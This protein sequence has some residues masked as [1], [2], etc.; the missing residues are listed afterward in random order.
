MSVTSIKTTGGWADTAVQDAYAL[1][2]GWAL[3]NSTMLW[4]L[5]DHMPEQ[6][7][8]PGGSVTEQLNAFYSAADVAAAVTALDEETDVTPVKSP[9]NSTVTYT[10]VERGF[11]NKRTIKLARRG[12]T[13]VDPVIARQVGQHAA[14]VHDRVVNLEARTGSQVLRAAGR[15]STATVAAGDNAAADDVRA[16]VTELRSNNAETRD[17]QFYVGVIHPKVVHDLRTEGGA[18]AWRTPKE[19][20]DPGEIYRGEFGEFEGV[21]FV[22]YN[23]IFLGDI[24]DDGASSA[25]VYRTLILGREALG[26]S[27][28]Q[29]PTVV[30]GPV[31]DSLKRFR[32]IGWYSDLDVQVYRDAALYRY[33]SASS[34]G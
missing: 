18:G 34:L 12:L 25:N 28:I 24:D 5:I 29:D 15:A 21:R 6:V 3:H 19:Y 16:I 9:A 2:F 11:T 26:K 27:V 33:E 30:L 32:T 10:P 31:V 4:P 23:G 17:G 20:V 13:P 1:K 7:P 22:Q 8:H 14:D